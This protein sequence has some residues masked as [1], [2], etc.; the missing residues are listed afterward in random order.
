MCVLAIVPTK[1]A[2]GLL[3]LAFA[4]VRRVALQR[5]NSRAN[6]GTRSILGAQNAR[7]TLS[8]HAGRETLCHTGS[9]AYRMANTANHTDCEKP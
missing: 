6:R 8:E 5:V 9:V 3:R 1:H 7:L 2:F 4:P